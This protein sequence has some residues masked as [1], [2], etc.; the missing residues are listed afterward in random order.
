MGFVVQV[1]DV[2]IVKGLQ[3]NLR[4]FMTQSLFVLMEEDNF[5]LV[6]IEVLGKNEECFTFI[7]NTNHGTLSR[8]YV[9]VVFTAPDRNITIDSVTIIGKSR[10]VEQL[11]HNG[12]SC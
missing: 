7:V 9:S 10:M 4:V 12:E 2:G 8:I 11:Q 1:Y 6:I 3:Q 5:T